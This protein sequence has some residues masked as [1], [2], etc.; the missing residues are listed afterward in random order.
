MSSLSRLVTSVTR[1]LNTK[2]GLEDIKEFIEKHP[3]GTTTGIATAAFKEAI[4]TVTSNVRWMKDNKESVVSWL[5]TYLNP[6]PQ[7]ALNYRLPQDLAPSTYRLSIKPYFTSTTKPE[8]YDGQVE[9]DFECLKNTK[10][11]VIHYNKLDLNYSTLEITSETDADFKTTPANPKHTYSPIT[12]FFALE[13][14]GGQQFKAGSKYTFK[15]DFVGYTKEDNLGFYASKYQDNGEKWIVSSQLET[16]EARKSFPCFDEPAM[17]AKFNLKLIH[18]SSLTAFSNMPIKQKQVTPGEETTETISVSTVGDTTEYTTVAVSTWVETE[19]EETPI[20]ST[21]L[22]AILLADYSC[23]EDTVKSKSG[24]DILSKV[25]TR[26]N[27]LDELA[28]ARNAS[29]GALEALESLYDVPY[30]LP[31]LDHVSSP[32]FNFGAMENWGLAIY[33]ERLFLKNENSTQSTEQRIVTIITHE[34]AHMWFGNLVTPKWWNDLWLNEG[35]ARYM[36]FVGA[37][38]LRPEWE[39]LEQHANMLLDVLNA[40]AGNSVRALSQDANTPEE[41]NAMVDPTITYGKGS[42]VVRMLNY[43]LGSESFYQALTAYFEKHKYTNV[44]QFDLWRAMAD[45]GKANNVQNLGQIDDLASVMSV[46]TKQA[47]HPVVTVTLDDVKDQLVVTQKQFKRDPLA[48]QGDFKWTI[49]FTYSIE[50]NVF[51][52]K[53]TE[54]DSMNISTIKDSI[55]WIKPTEEVTTI[56]LNASPTQDNFVLANI[57]MT[58]YY[59]VNYDPENWAKIIK[60]LEKDKVIIFCFVTNVFHFYN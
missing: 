45:K 30:P 46:W 10:Q 35:F 39:L 42:G 17:K 24:R 26:K 54:M 2:K 21:Y 25:C 40:D 27:A 52:D 31:K 15:V 55:D 18:D 60:Q 36:Q 33:L 3:E 28:L 58:G 48:K 32:T 59:R 44:D 5:R 57:E 56:D 23:I 7:P 12:H 16:V 51:L 9:I 41:I 50:S 38:E 20:M 34:I 22:L 14:P 13:F 47:G 11:F 29:I 53:P 49:P 4:E 43:V 6:P 19:F 37:N 8:K 1:K